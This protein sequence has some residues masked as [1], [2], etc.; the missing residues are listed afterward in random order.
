[1]EVQTCQISFGKHA[2]QNCDTINFSSNQFYYI[3]SVF[4]SVWQLIL[5]VR[6]RNVIFV[7]DLVSEA[8]LLLIGGY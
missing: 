3:I 8:K 7:L 5:M 4:L 2:C 6:R 1:M